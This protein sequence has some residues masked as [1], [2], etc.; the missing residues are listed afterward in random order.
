MHSDTGYVESDVPKTRSKSHV[1]ASFD[2]SV[3]YSS[4]THSL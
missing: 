3:R 1:F 2:N 4:F